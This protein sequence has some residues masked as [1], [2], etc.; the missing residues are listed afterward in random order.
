MVAEFPRQPARERQVGRRVAGGQGREDRG[1]GVLRAGPR[2]GRPGRPR[3]AGMPRS[4]ATRSAPNRKP[5]RTWGRA[6]SRAGHRT[7][8][9]PRPPGHPQER[10]LTIRESRS[11]RGGRRRP[12]EPPPF[13]R[14]VFL[15]DRCRRVELALR[16]SVH[17]RQRFFRA[18]QDRTTRTGQGRT[19][20]WSARDRGAVQIRCGLD[21][22]GAMHV[23]PLPDVAAVANGDDSGDEAGGFQLAEGPLGLA[24]RP[25]A[26]RRGELVGWCPLAWGPAAGWRPGHGRHGH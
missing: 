24:D 23:D 15:P 9:A 16:I 12:R 3:V 5:R 22:G 17:L 11:W 26:A 4:W 14:G 13:A 25:S 6:S 2:P 8:P 20:G 19:G 21:G 18:G 1:R 7:A 10:G